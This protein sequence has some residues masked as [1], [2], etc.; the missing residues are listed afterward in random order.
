MSPLAGVTRPVALFALRPHALDVVLHEL[1]H[2]FLGCAVWCAQASWHQQ[3][4]GLTGTATRMKMLI[5]RGCPG[6]WRDREFGVARDGNAEKLGMASHAPR[7]GPKA[8]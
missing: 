5:D 2:P 7:L 6:R 4:H 8:P 1:E 3:H